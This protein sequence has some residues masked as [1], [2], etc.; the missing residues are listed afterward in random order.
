[1]L[2]TQ[3]FGVGGSGDSF[4]L[5]STSTPNEMLRRTGTALEVV[6][7]DVRPSHA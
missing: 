2:L 1:M 6:G 4:T 3:R 5:P 7:E